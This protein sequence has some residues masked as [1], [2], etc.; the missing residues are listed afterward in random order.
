M[1]VILSLKN[2]LGLQ[3]IPAG[4]ELVLDEFMYICHPRTVFGYLFSL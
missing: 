1:A 2:P 4:S 3:T